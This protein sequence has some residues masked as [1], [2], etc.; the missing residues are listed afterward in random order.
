MC[1]AAAPDA[2][3]RARRTGPRSALLRPT[4][5]SPSP[6]PEAAGLDRSIS[7]G[8]SAVGAGGSPIRVNGGPT[9]SLSG[10]LGGGRGGLTDR[11][12]RRADR[13]HL[14]GLDQDRGHLAGVRRLQLD[15]RLRG[16]DL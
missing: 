3:L 4:S 11:D 14:A 1:A 9:R 8:A 12:D 16:L 5:D 10:G 6:P 15:D 7:T 13:D 2:T